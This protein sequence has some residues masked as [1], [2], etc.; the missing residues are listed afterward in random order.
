MLCTGLLMSLR[1]I[2]KAAEIYDSDKN[3]L[4]IKTNSFYGFFGEGAAWM[5][6]AL[7][8]IRAKDV[9]LPA[10]AYNFHGILKYS[11]S[12]LAALVPV[13][14]ALQ[15]NF[16]WL[17]IFAPLIFYWAEAQFVFLFPLLIDNSPSP[18]RE[19]LRL[20]KNCGGAGNVMLGVMPLAAVMLLGG[21]F[22]KGF[23]RSWCLGCLA[24]LL[25]YE[26]VKNGI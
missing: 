18:Y 26:E 4:N 1:L 21:F 9:P 5:S 14:L 16:I 8:I 13:F 19:S 22:G 15:L 20:T 3:G 11:L 24:V 10:K 6:E 23:T 7:R 25:W 17:V 12:I 2:S